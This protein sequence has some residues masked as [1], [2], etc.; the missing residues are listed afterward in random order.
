MFTHIF[1]NIDVPPLWLA[2]AALGVAV[3][4]YILGCFN[5]S[6]GTMYAPTAAA[7]PA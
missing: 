3:V 4:A 6:C 1:E 5:G 2:A 7:T